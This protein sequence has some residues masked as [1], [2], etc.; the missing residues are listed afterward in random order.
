MTNRRQFLQNTATVFGGSLLLTATGQQAFA[1]FNNS[2]APSDQLNIGAIGINGM[3]WADVTAALKIPGVN[4]VALCD[5]DKNVLDKRLNDLGK[6]NVDASKLKTYSDYRQLLDRKD[7]DAVIIGTPDHWHAMIMMHA[8]QAGKDVY[9]E[10]PVG[11]SIM[12]CR[13]MFSAQQP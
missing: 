2:I 11:N 3:G 1:T 8:C 13:A 6:M 5:V 10:K 4:L 12:E 7:I 9:V